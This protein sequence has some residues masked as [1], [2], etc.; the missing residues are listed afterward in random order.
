MLAMAAPG[1]VA[2]WT[3]YAT[4]SQ[5]FSIPAE[6]LVLGRDLLLGTTDD[7]ISRVHARVAREGGQILVSDA[8]SRNGTYVNGE[9]IGDR[10]VDVTPGSV[11]RTGRTLWAVVADA[12]A[13][14]IDK[15]VRAHFE[16]IRAVAPE[17][18]IHASVF[19][20]C[21]L[22]S[23]SDDRLA[24]AVAV[25]VSTREAG[26]ALRGEDLAIDDTVSS[27]VWCVFPGA[28]L[29]RASADRLAHAIVARGFD[30]TTREAGDGNWLVEA[31][32]EE[33]R[34]AITCPPSTAFR[35]ELSD[36]SLV[37]E[38]HTLDDDVAIACS[39]A[40][41][42]GTNLD[43]LRAGKLIWVSLEARRPDG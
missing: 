9:H 1:V 13:F 8:G 19:E 3:G 21:L 5:A 43:E 33:R 17:L 31:G 14:D 40:W 18:E 20:R 2:V 6:G 25:A 12:S 11:I 36:A 41:L 27:A 4:G 30:A 15:T 29:A 10:S 16:T 26:G 7:R 38:G 42:G 23:A 24:R 39:A 35:L 28:E 37:M 32:H 22:S 34:V